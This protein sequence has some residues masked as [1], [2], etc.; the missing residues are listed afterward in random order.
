KTV[1]QADARMAEARELQEES[2]ACLARIEG[3]L[4]EAERHEM[5]ALTVRTMQPD[6]V[7]RFWKKQLSAEVM[8]PTRAISVDDVIDESVHKVL[9][10]FLIS[11]LHEQQE[12]YKSF[13][14]DHLRRPL[15][16][17]GT[18]RSEDVAMLAHS[19]A[20]GVVNAL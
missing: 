16:L 17:Y 20:Y 7:S 12:L 6:S 14:T 1:A 4:S 5:E 13:G 15:V 10:H 19:F 9:A 8:D 3:D 11:W 18:L 2:K